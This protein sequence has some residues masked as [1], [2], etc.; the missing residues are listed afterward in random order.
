LGTSASSNEDAAIGRAY[1]AYQSGNFQLVLS[2]FEVTSPNDRKLPIWGLLAGAALCRLGQFSL[3]D[4]HLQSALKADPD[5]VD[6][7]TWLALIHAGNEDPQVPLSYANRAIKL[8]PQ[9]ATCQSVLG[10]VYLRQ[11]R[12]E[13]AAEPLLTARKLEPKIALHWHNLGQ[14]YLALQKNDDALKHFRTAVELAKEDPQNYLALASALSMFGFV[15]DAISCLLDAVKHCPQNA[16]LHSALANYFTL[17]RNDGEA[18]VQHK[19][20]V[21]IDRRMVTAYGAWLVNQGRFEESNKIFER[22]IDEENDVAF[23]YYNQMLS[24]KLNGTS[25]DLAFFGDMREQ[26][27]VELNPKG[28]MYLHYACGRAAEQLKHFEEAAIHYE[29][30]NRLAFGIHKQFVKVSENRFLLE[31]EEQIETYQLLRESGDPPGNLSEAP[32][33]IVGM[34]RSGT[35]LLDQI[36]SSHSMVASSGELRFWIEET[37]KVS[38]R[39]RDGSPHHLVD[40]AE[41]YLSYAKM[42][43]RA[44]SRFTDKMPLNYS[45]IGVIHLALPKAKFIH[46][47][48]HPIDTCLSIWTTYFGQGP[49]FGYSKDRIVQAYGA[50]LRAMEFWRETIPAQNLLEVSYE[51]IIR[52]PKPQI[53]RMIDF[54]GLEWEDSCLSHDQNSSAINTPSRWQARQPIYSSSIERW[55]NFEPWLGEFAELIK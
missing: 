26:L 8:D 28:Q 20:A 44:S 51:E 48:R 47:R 12:P 15:G 17:V 10:Q 4:P 29:K 25:A 32:I 3:A 43:A 21:Q 54:L 37:K 9:N 49:A 35:T 22:A 42:L 6:A 40:L 33:F 1:A 30:S 18:E 39:I 52:N 7:L 50:Y 45:G 5:A 24:R 53:R 46:I 23:S 27:D 14:C 2:V 34:I 41:D 38:M 55:R 31:V 11:F 36:L 16:Q 13:I 19:L